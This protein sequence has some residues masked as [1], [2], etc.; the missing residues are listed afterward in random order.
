MSVPEIAI[1]FNLESL[2]VCCSGTSLFEE[3]LDLRS[4]LSFRFT[5]SG[6]DDRARFQ[7][8]DIGRGECD[9]I[10]I[11]FEHAKTGHVPK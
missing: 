11:E 9:R 8:Q 2:A 10:V 1:R 5:C 7:L 3:L 6:I 4:E